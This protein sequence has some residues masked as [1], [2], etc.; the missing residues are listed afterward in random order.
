VGLPDNAEAE[1]LRNSF[2]LG[3]NL[4][5]AIDATHMESDGV[6]ADL[7]LSTRSF[8]RRHSDFSFG[9][10]SRALTSPAYLCGERRSHAASQREM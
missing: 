6:Y 4:E 3:M 1:R 9:A 8:K 10:Y 2:R 5:L 7:W